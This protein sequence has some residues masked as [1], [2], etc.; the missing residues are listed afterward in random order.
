MKTS[1]N[2][3][4]LIEDFL[5]GGNSEGE[6]TLMQARLLLQPSLKESI[7]WQQKTYQ[8]VNTYGRGQLRQE[9]AQVHQKLF[10]APEHLSFRQKVMRFFAK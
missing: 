3:L 7:S 6:S 2:E 8:L 1:L 5:L 9:I 4:L 10:S